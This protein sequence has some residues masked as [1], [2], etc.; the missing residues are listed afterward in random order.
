[1]WPGLCELF[2]NVLDGGTQGPLSK[3]GDDTNLRGMAGRQ[4]G[5]AAVHRDTQRWEKCF[6]IPH[7]NGGKCQV[8]Q[9][10]RNNS[11]HS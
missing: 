11:P 3:F 7:A 10:G 6:N 9:L 1:M 4:G 8:L 5:C 2:I